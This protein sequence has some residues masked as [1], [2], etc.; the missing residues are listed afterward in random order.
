LLAFVVV[1]EL[2]A[3]PVGDGFFVWVFPGPEVVAGFVC[4]FGVLVDPSVASGGAGSAEGDAVGGFVPP[5]GVGP[6]A[7]RA[8]VT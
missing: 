2:V 7:V 4:G 1:E 6:E 3:L 5:C 8:M